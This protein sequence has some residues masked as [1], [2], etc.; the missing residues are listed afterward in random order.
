MSENGS[1][2]Q[3]KFV[4]IDTQVFRKARFDW[5]GRSLSKLVEFAKQ[6]HLRLLVT[7]VT[8]RE[9]KSQLREILTETNSSITKHSGILEQLGASVAVE[10]LRDQAAALGAL[11]AAFDEF[12]KSTRALHVPLVSEV[13]GIL[14]DYFSLRPPFSA[15]KKSEFPDAIS[16]SSIRQ[17]CEKNKS[18]AYIVSADPDL[19]DCCSEAGPLFYAESIEQI[20]SK[21]TVSQELHDS[22]E[23]ALRESEYLSERLAEEIK[24]SEVNI[25]RW[26]MF[27]RG[28]AIEAAKIDDVYSVNVISLSVLEQDGLTFI[29]EPEVE[30]EIGLE[31]DIEID[32]R[33]GYGGPED[34]EP[35]RSERISITKT[36]YFYPEVIVHFVSS[37]GELEFKSISLGI[38]SVETSL[39]DLEGHLGR[40]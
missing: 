18:M 31:I 23:K 2:L 35:T 12:L 29:C 21:A 11:E 13:K 14:D 9:V 16:I 19:R 28:I 27:G 8:A 7:D 40:R 25:R 5:K 4:F 24:G 1:H 39:D 3:T 22:L 34:Y 32:G 6:S 37:T 10:R 20:I 17:W 36:D 30:V 33:Y 38:Q 26:S 15:K